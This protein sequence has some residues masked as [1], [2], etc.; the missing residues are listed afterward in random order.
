MATRY[1]GNRHT[2]QRSRGPMLVQQYFKLI[3]CTVSFKN[4]NRQHYQ[5]ISNIVITNKITQSF[6]ASA[7]H[8][9]KLHSCLS[10]ISSTAALLPWR[11]HPNERREAM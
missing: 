3:K 4:T 10:G 1:C 6:F 9:L 11:T 2:H 7:I 5:S 8:I